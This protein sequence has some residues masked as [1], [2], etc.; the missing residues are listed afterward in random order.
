[1]SR[2]ADLGVDLARALA[3]NDGLAV[4]QVLSDARAYG[5]SPTV[6]SVLEVAVAWSLR[7]GR[8]GVSS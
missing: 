7:A 1:V 8:A 3:D 5:G 4:A 2:T 6:R